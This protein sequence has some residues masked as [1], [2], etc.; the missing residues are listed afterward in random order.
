MPAK[1]P[2]LTFTPTAKSHALLTRL[3]AVSRSPASTVCRDMLETLEDHLEML[4]LVSEQV[5]HLNEGARQ[6][7]HEAA[8][9]AK[10]QLSPL[11]EEAA[12][13]MLKMATAIDEPSLPLGEAPPP[14]SNT[15]VT[16]RA[17]RRAA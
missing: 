13:I 12:R 5:A 10:R 15:G 9:E 2:R 11:M 8:G 3:A 1:S 6:A 4:V 7:A 17:S 14:S 16:E